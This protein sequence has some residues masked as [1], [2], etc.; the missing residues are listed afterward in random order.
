MSK[1]I[2]RLKE[3]DLTTLGNP[4][5]DRY[6]IGIDSN[7]GQFFIKDEAGTVTKPQPSNLGGLTDVDLTGLSTNDLLQYDGANWV[8]FTLVY[9]TNL[10]VNKVDGPLTTTSTTPASALSELLASVEAGDYLLHVSYGWNHDDTGSDFQGIV[11]YDGNI[12]GF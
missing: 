10:R 5:A 1:P 7:D 2:I 4:P 9:G 11:T 8:P 12:L 3:V 6:Y